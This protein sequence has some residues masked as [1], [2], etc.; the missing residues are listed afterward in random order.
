M[1][2]LVPELGEFVRI[3]LEL[4]GT[5]KLTQP[6]YN[7]YKAAIKAIA[8]KYGAKQTEG[9]HIKIADAYRAK[10]TAIERAK[11]KKHPR[12]KGAK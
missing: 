12:K 6:K 5:K 11:T 4:E 7:A 8:K 10:V 1:G 9:E 3:V 2:C